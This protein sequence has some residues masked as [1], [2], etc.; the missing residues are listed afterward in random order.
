MVLIKIAFEITRCS[1]IGGSAF[2]LTASVCLF[3]GLCGVLPDLYKP[4]VH[5]TAVL[6]R[7]MNVHSVGLLHR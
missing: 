6:T 3:Q 1:Q 2:R 5:H 7:L 4:P